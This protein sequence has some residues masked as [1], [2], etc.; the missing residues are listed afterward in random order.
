MSKNRP[1]AKR[2]IRAINEKFP[3]LEVD[4]W[5][6]GG[7]TATLTIIPTGGLEPDQ[8]AVLVGPGTYDWGTP[9]RSRFYFEDL[10]VGLH[11]GGIADSIVCKTVDDV[12]NGVGWFADASGWL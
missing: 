11:D 10:S 9:E 4:V 3:S 12:V 1:R 5:Q 7:G 2:L 8:V 6:S